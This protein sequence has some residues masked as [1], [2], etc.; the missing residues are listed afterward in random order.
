MC[1]THKYFQKLCT[2]IPNV[3]YTTSDTAINVYRA[4]KLNHSNQVEWWHLAPR[5]TATVN[6]H[7]WEKF[8]NISDMFKRVNGILVN[9]HIAT[10]Y[11]DE[12]N[13]SD[14]CPNIWCNVSIYWDLDN[15]LQ[16]VVYVAGF[17]SVMAEKEYLAENNTLGQVIAILV[18][19][20]ISTLFFPS[21]SE[22]QW[23]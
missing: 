4:W 13:S 16:R 14:P 5:A 17:F 1:L 6:K 21:L 8:K 18:N 20:L 22:K 10:K 12:D 23:N 7:G 11:F 19:L 2:Q 15:S 9:W 3:M